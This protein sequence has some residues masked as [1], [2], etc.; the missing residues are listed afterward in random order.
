MLVI[1]LISLI[2]FRPRIEYFQKIQNVSNLLLDTIV[3][4]NK[5]NIAFFVGESFHAKINMTHGL[6]LPKMKGEEL[7]IS[8]SFFMTKN[9]VLVNHV[10]EILNRLIEAGIEKYHSEYA[11]WIDIRPSK[12]EP[13]DT[14]RI[15]SLNDLEYGFVLWLAACLGSFLVFVYEINSLRLR[16]KLRVL[17]GLVDF[18]RLM[19]ARMADYHD[20]W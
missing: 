12:D 17:I 5:S 16:R 18:L 4:K 8:F 7:L 10:D 15:F 2:I 20:T 14:R 3:G 9:N 19:R 11:K 6:S 13:E 1:L